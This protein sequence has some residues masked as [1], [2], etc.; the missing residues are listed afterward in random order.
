MVFFHVIYLHATKPFYRKKDGRMASMTRF[1][2]WVR[3]MST[4]NQLI[5]G[6]GVVTGMS[7]DEAVRPT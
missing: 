3:P 1:N 4:P 7:W 6:Y 2:A 5:L